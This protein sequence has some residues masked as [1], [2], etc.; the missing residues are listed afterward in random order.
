[1]PPM[2]PLAGGLPK[3]AVNLAGAVLTAVSLIAPPASGQRVSLGVVVGGYANEDFD[4]RYVPCPG[5]LPSITESDSGGYVIGPSL[6]VRLFP[7]LSIGVEALYKPL[8]YR[9]AAS[10]SWEGE[11]LGFAPAT[12]VTW[13]LPVLARYRFSLGRLRP[14]L[15]GGPSFRS[16]GNLNSSEP[17]HF[18]VSAGGGVETEWRRLRIAPRVRYTRWA[19]DTWVPRVRTRSDQVEFLVGF[20]Y[21]AAVNAHPLGRRILLG[22]VIGPDVSSESEIDKYVP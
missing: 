18:G 19:E 22:A 12:V 16:T 8:H 20:S 3:T 14:F 5:Y 6:D 10:M 1:M 15:E 2:P 7:R 11:V 9:A 17:S 13:Q 21:A 4:S